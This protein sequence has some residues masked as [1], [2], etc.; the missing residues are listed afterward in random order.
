MKKKIQVT[1]S[2][3]LLISGCISSEKAEE[4]PVAPEQNFT[5]FQD[6]SK[7]DPLD[8]IEILKY[9]PET[10]LEILEGPPSD[11]IKEQHVSELMTLIDS[12]EPASPVVSLLSSYYPFNQT[13]TVG[14]EA[15]FLIEGYRTG[16]Y[17][18]RLSSLY[19]FNGS[20]EEFREWWEIMEKS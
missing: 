12:Q 11:W 8:F 3:L 9:A 4:K 14:N 2:I 20:P 6:W 17:P 15:M 10:P 5:T 18:P 16:R 1:I 19:Y 13:S 7:I